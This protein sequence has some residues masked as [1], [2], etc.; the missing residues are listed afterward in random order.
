MEGKGKF[1]N[2]NLIPILCHFQY[3]CWELPC[4]TFCEFAKYLPV[5]TCMGKK[6][7]QGKALSKMIIVRLECVQLRCFGD[8]TDL[9][10]TRYQ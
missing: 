3:E 8:K 5:L 2:K 6:L 7:L 1:S 9:K 4:S 10:I